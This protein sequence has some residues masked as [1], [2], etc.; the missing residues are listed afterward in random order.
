MR[1]IE[2]RD[3]PAG[4]ITFAA[5]LFS[6]AT[7]RGDASAPPQPSTPGVATSPDLGTPLPMQG[8]LPA[9]TGVG[10][11]YGVEAI[12]VANVPHVGLG[13]GV[14]TPGGRATFAG[15]D[16]DEYIGGHRGRSGWFGFATLG[17][18]MAAQVAGTASDAFASGGTGYN[19][20]DVRY[21]RFDLPAPGLGFRT[22]NWVASMQLAPDLEL[23]A[24]SYRG[25][26]ATVSGDALVFALAADL[27]AC[28]QYNLFGFSG[29]NSSACGYVAPVLFR[30]GG[31]GGAAFGV[32][33]FM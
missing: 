24:A 32:R 22:R 33:V 11:G 6:A 23:F 19:A 9:F 30:D 21:Y 28:R 16:V 26:M 25:P 4:A 29:R 15:F 17:V 7:A 3:A 1:P 20:G 10:I 5:V 13:H 2:L 31:F 12:D 14:A 18:A 27:Q 8:A